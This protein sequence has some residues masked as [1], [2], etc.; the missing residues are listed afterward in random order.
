MAHYLRHVFEMQGPFHY[1]NDQDE[2]DSIVYNKESEY[3]R[4]VYDSYMKSKYYSMCFGLKTKFKLFNICNFINR[5][6][7]T[8]L[9][10]KKKTKKKIKIKI[11]K[12]KATK[13]YL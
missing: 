3:F 5:I 11:K 7:N 8:K 4:G 13:T 1:W 9:N 10:A 6:T 2:N 12:K